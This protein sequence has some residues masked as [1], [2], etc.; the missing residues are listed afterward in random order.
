MRYKV[1][2]KLSYSV[3]YSNGIMLVV[4]GVVKDFTIRLS[5]FHNTYNA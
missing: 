3:H 4:N 2:K 5:S 1:V